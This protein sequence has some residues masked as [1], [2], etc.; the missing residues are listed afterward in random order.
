VPDPAIL[1]VTTDFGARDAY[2]AAVKGVV[3]SLEPDLRI[4]DV[5]HEIGPQDVMQ[6]AF[7]LRGVIPFF[8]PGTVHLVVVDPGV[9]T[10]RRAIAAR[11][12]GHLFVGP[13][14]GLF[15]L[16][17]QGPPDEL[18][19]LDRPEYWRSPEPSATFHGRDVFAPVAARLAGGVPLA[20]VGSPS[21]GLARLHWA[22]P[23]FDEQ[24]VRGWVVH[25]D[26]FG[27]CISNIPRDAFEAQRRGR[28][29]KC[30]VG[31]T[32][33]DELSATYGAVAAGEPVLLFDSLDLLEVAVFRGSATE[34]LE[35]RAGAPV[36]LVFTEDRA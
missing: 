31:N 17:F 11:K 20:E 24:G 34:Q 8:P 4:V 28:R 32:I 33:I 27:N 16:L 26:G 25:V 19:V 36:N 30:Y 18:V 22:L 13:D 5:T 7:V 6:A 35:I 14:N 1:T 21:S 2:V 15:S 9:G 29:F 23:I 10:D 3:L 12:D